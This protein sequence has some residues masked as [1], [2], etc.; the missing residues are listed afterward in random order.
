MIGIIKEHKAECGV[1]RETCKER[2]DEA[3][4]QGCVP[5]LN[6]YSR[7]SWEN[8]PKSIDTYEAWE[9]AGEFARIMIKRQIEQQQAQL[10][11]CYKLLDAITDY[12]HEDA[13]FQANLLA[14]I[15]RIKA[16]G[17]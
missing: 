17:E 12:A 4:A 8:L 10:E 9:M 13:E 2:F 15:K 14:D 1:W 7:V 11:A 16:M 6:N 5:I 3:L